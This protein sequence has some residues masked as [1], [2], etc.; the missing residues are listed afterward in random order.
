MFIWCEKNTGR[1]AAMLQHQKI[2][3]IKKTD[4]KIQYLFLH[5]KY[6]FKIPLKITRKYSW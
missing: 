5:I 1:L 6:T 3:Q 4:Q 2:A